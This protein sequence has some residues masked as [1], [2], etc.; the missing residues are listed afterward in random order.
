MK[1]ITTVLVGLALSATASANQHD[2]SHKF[3]AGVNVGG[4]FAAL[5]NASKTIEKTPGMSK[6]SKNYVAADLHV[7]KRFGSFGAEFSAGLFDKV[8]TKSSANVA[9]V[10][11]LKSTGYLFALDLGY[12]IP[13]S[14]HVS[15]RPTIGF[16]GLFSQQVSSIDAAKTTKNSFKLAPKAGLGLV[17][18]VH[19]DISLTAAANFVCPISNKYVKYVMNAN[20]GANYH[21]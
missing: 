21:F 18:A 6:F 7:G 3:Y 20:V 12:Y 9:P 5:T 4:S 2:L 11:K 19:Q 13:L 1:K 10:T 14:G 17:F 16:G 15:F 8:S